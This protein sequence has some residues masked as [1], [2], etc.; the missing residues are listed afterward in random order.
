M[1]EPR[2]PW[3]KYQEPK[4]RVCVGE[5]YVEAES[6][7]LGAVSYSCTRKEWTFHYSDGTEETVTKREPLT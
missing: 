2:L 4:R 6:T 7:Y 5:E 1:V 3:P